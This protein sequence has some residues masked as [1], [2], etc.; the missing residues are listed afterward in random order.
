M[1][2]GLAMALH[3]APTYTEYSDSPVVET[4]EVERILARRGRL[5]V[6]GEY[7][8]TAN[9]ATVALAVPVVD[10]L[11]GCTTLSRLLIDVL[12]GSG[13]YSQCIPF[14]MQRVQGR[15]PEHCVRTKKT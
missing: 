15:S 2:A 14:S 4:S 10:L 8:C 6:R 5:A 12:R 9:G 3:S 13:A 7:G 11:R 1:D